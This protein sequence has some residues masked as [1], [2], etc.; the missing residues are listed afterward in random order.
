MKD[1]TGLYNAILKNSKGEAIHSFNVKV[2]SPPGAPEGPLD[3]SD[4]HAD[5]CKL[6]WNPPKVNM[7][8]QKLIFEI[9]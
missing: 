1:D 2:Y 8:Y 3:V 5:S 4:V 9:L 7:I 6:C